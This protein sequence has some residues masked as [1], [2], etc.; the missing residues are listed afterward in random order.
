M[1]ATQTQDMVLHFDSSQDNDRNASIHYTTPT[2]DP[3]DYYIN[4]YGRTAEPNRMTEILHANLSTIVLDGPIGPTGIQGAKGDPGGVTGHQGITGASGITGPLGPQGAIGPT[5][6]STT[7]DFFEKAIPLE[8]WR[9][10]GHTPTFYGSLSV[11]EFNAVSDKMETVIPVPYEWD[12]T[13]NMTIKVGLFTGNTSAVSGTAAFEVNYNA[14]DAGASEAAIIGTLTNVTASTS[15][16]FSRHEYVELS[17]TIP[18]GNIAGKDY[19]YLRIKPDAIT[20]PSRFGVSNT[21]VRY[22]VGI[23]AGPTGPVGVQGPQGIQGPTGAFGGPPGETGVQGPQGETGAQG[24]TGNMGAVGPAGRTF[25]RDLDYTYVSGTSSSSITNNAEVALNNTDPSSATKIWFQ[26]THTITEGLNVNNIEIFFDQDITF[27]F[28][29]LALGSDQST[30]NFYRITGKSGPFPGGGGENVYEFDVE[31]INIVNG[32]PTAQTP[33][34][35]NTIF[36]IQEGHPGTTGIQGD[37]GPQGETGAIGSTGVKGPTGIKGPTGWQGETGVRGL[38]GPGVTGLKGPTGIQGPT[39]WQGETGARGLTGAGIQGETGLR[40]P[41]GIEGSTGPDGRAYSGSVNPI[42]NSSAGTTPSDSEV[43]LNTSDPSSTTV[44]TL[45]TQDT[46]QGY[47]GA[48]FYYTVAVRSYIKLV[49]KDNNDH[50]NYYLVTSKSVDSLYYTFNVTHDP[51]KCTFQTSNTNY[52]G[53]SGEVYLVITAEPGSLGTSGTQGI[54]GFRGPTGI[55]GETGARGLTGAGIQGITGFR[56]PTGIQGETGARGLTGAGIQGITGFRGPTG[57]QGETGA[58]GLTGAGIQGITGLIGPTGTQGETGVG[59]AGPQGITG[60]RGFTGSQGETGPQGAGTTG[61]QGETGVA[62]FTSGNVFPSSPEN[63]Q[64]Y[65]DSD[66]E[67]VYFYD[68]TIDAWID[69]SSGTRNVTGI[70]GPTGLQGSQG[71]TGV[72]LELENDPSPELSAEMNAGL[73][74]IG[75]SEKDNGDSGTTGAI[76]WTTSNKQFLNIND[77]TMLAFS[78]PSYAGNY[79]LRVLQSSTGIV[80]FPTTGIYWVD[81]IAPALSTETGLVDFVSFYFDGNNYYGQASVGFQ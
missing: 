68:E 63:R 31:H 7:F 4:V 19:I 10:S 17:F 13:T 18:A 52:A 23:A 22:Y 72:S 46:V 67:I 3:G 29:R 50:Y 73:H 9:F 15:K 53:G 16:S 59:V 6:A 21:T 8:Q 36:L 69:I 37:I 57:I 39:G 61:V 26:A 77:H 35:G 14:F 66:D 30:Y 58:R 25:V 2:L 20:T 49:D 80:S 33:Y 71:E 42:F 55:Q 32:F 70:Q 28:L 60:F 1:P 54:T 34:V 78:N 65:W 56:G 5:G 38:T 51:I 47:G 40:G 62:N 45:S 27:G 48:D 44:I 74:S 12:G 81:G 76:D 64:L 24:L 75:F 41:T 11:I 79:Q 43:Q